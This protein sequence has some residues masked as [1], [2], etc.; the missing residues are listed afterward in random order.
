[1]HEEK[2][3]QKLQPQSKPTLKTKYQNKS[4]FFFFLN[5]NHN[6]AKTYPQNSL[7]SLAINPKNSQQIFFSPFMVYQYQIEASPSNN[8][9]T[10]IENQLLEGIKIEK[11]K[12]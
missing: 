4:F 1:M 10:K 3:K 6:P 5:P 12:E 11:R 8:H 9:S 2:V 7:P